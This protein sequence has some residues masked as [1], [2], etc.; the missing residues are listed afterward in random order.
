[1]RPR[2]ELQPVPLAPL[3]RADR[4]FLRDAAAKGDTLRQLA[5]WSGRPEAEIRAVV[6]SA[7]P[8]QPTP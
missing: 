2:V 6:T 7:S 3:T 4:E 8:D 1:M 5:T